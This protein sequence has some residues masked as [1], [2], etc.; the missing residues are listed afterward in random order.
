MY[1][2]IKQPKLLLVAARFFANTRIAATGAARNK[3]QHAHISM[4]VD[5]HM[6]FVPLLQ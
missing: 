5:R 2:R 6:H 1:A 3:Q 4:Y